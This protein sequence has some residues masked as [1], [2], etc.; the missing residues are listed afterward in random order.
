VRLVFFGTAPFCLPSLRL[1]H[2]SEEVVALVTRPD[3]PR[4]RGLRS[5]PSPAK[6]LACQLGIPVLQPEGLRQEHFLEKLRDL[7]PEVIALSAYGGILPPEVLKLPL[8]G[9]VNLH[10][11]LLPRWRGATP[12]AR[13]ILEGEARTGLTTFLMTEEMD[14]GPILLQEAVEIEPQEDAGSLERR[15]AEQG[16]ELLVRTLRLLRRGELRPREQDHARATYAPPLRGEER[17]LRWE[18][19]A[20]RVINHIRALSPRPGAL[21]TFQGRPVKA[22]K[23][24]LGR[25]R[26]RPGQVLGPRGEAMEVATGR[27]SVLLEVVQ[28]SGKRP[29]SGAAF[30]RGYRPQNLI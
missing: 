12:I 1:L 18:E 9:C 6:E 8:L 25:A 30:L 16:A 10:P 3:R 21:F 11:S 4:G 29:M 2:R 23:V 27:G 26:G 13:A 20:Q 5:G 28:P 24:F 15:L 14:A 17:W 7:E 22:L 19:D